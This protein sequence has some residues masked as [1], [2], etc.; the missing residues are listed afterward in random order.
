M[1]QGSVFERLRQ[2]VWDGYQ[3][4]AAIE[5]GQLQQTQFGQQVLAAQAVGCP[6]NQKECVICM[7]V[8]SVVVSGRSMR[9]NKQSHHSACRT[10][11]CCLFAS[12]IDAKAKHH[13]DLGCG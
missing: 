1:A 11:W 13:T 8:L 9:I 3:T 4:W 7:Q 12:S 5:L 10:R 2:A 6:V